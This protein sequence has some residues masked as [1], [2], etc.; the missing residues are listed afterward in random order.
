M[1]IPTKNVAFTIAF[2]LFAACSQYDISVNDR[3][4]YT[5]APLFKDY[6]IDDLHLKQCI[7][8]TITDNKI[9]GLANFTRLRCTHAGITDLAGLEKFYAL[10]ELDLSDNAITDTEAVA[11][12][13][14]LEVL[15]L[16][17]NQL[18]EVSSLLTLIRLSEL[19]LTGNDELEC[20]GLAQL[21]KA[22]ED[23][24]GVLVA[25]EHCDS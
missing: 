21:K 9:T 2:A 22:I 24:S 7:D 23:N 25:P 13:G 20:N 6:Q 18:T 17:N 4:V 19:V 14:R 1:R 15:L 3:V 11:R 12:L 5:P 8:Q 10:T 16:E